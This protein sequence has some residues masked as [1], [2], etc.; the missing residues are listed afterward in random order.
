MAEIDAG[1]LFQ[2]EFLCRGNPTVSGNNPL[3]A[4]NEDRV[5]ET[6]LVR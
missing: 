6:E 2:S 4:V 1:N 5:R 3:I